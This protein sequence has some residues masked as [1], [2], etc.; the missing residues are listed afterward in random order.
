MLYVQALE[1]AQ[2]VTDTLRA[3]SLSAVYPLGEFIHCDNDCSL[4]RVWANDL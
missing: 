2:G 3:D 4:E 1:C